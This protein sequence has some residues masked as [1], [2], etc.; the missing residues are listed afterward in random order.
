MRRRTP[1]GAFTAAAQVS[2]RPTVHFRWH[3]RLTTGMHL[4]NLRYS[5]PR[6]TCQAQ[7][8]SLE[9]RQQLIV[10]TPVVALANRTTCMTN[11][12]IS[13]AS[14]CRQG[15]AVHRTGA[16]TSS[17]VSKLLQTTSALSLQSPGMGARNGALVPRPKK[18]SH[19]PPHM[20]AA[21]QVVRCAH[22]NPS[23]PK[24]KP[25]PRA[26]QTVSASCTAACMTSEI[27]DNVRMIKVEEKV[28]G[29]EHLLCD[30]L[31][32]KRLKSTRSLKNDLDMVEDAMQRVLQGTHPSALSAICR[33]AKTRIEPPRRRRNGGYPRR[34]LPPPK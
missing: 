17:S 33:G 30:E 32:R 15:V 13:H 11:A 31:H 6:A 22:R 9:I 1:K 27:L 12:G 16:P 10:P 21:A 14:P 8:G 2:H 3:Q 7:R 23:P 24:T 26:T 20:T 19:Q 5:P 25:R 28:A 34:R 18:K 29:P 4:R